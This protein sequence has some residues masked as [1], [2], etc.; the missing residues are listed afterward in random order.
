[1]QRAADLVLDT[2]DLCIGPQILLGIGGEVEH[3]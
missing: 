3:A 2:M 1:M